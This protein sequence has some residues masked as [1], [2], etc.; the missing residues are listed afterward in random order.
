MAL[1]L[2][3]SGWL[4]RQAAG[5]GRRQWSRG[6]MLTRA[7]AA[8]DLRC[9]C[10]GDAAMR[11]AASAACCVQRTVS[12]CP[13]CC[14]LLAVCCLAAARLA[15]VV[16]RPNSEFLQASPVLMA[17][18]TA[19]DG[20]EAFNIGVGESKGKDSKDKLE[21]LSRRSAQ[22]PWPQARQAI[23]AGSAAS[24]P[25]THDSWPV[26]QH[27]PCVGGKGAW[28]LRRRGHRRHRDRAFLGWRHHVERQ[29]IAPS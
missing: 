25:W 1:P 15:G 7:R 16:L 3:L 13:A 5:G 24:V 8:A 9:C 20:L 28:Q 2:S 18:R 29:D 17:L 4:S 27:G 14:L 26:V 12:C 19:S 6:H 21:L 10:A 23:G 22:S 11:A